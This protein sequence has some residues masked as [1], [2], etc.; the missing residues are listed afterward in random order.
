M[1]TAF[2][3]EL[4]K[5]AEEE[6]RIWL[7]C[8]DLGY[9]VLER[10]RDRFPNRYVNVGVAEQN[11]TG[12]AAG[13]ALCGKIV[14]TYS[15]ANF[16]VMRCLEQIR[17]DICYHHAN[18]KIVAVGG[19]LAYGAQGYTHHGVEDLAVM[20]VLPEMTVI[21]PGDPV[22]TRLATRAIVSYNGPCYL[23]L[24]KAG[25]PIVHQTDPK[26]EIGKAILMRD[27]SSLTLISTGGMLATVMQAAQRL[28][29]NGIAA[30][31]LS[32][33]TL[34]PLDREAILAAAAETG[35]IVTVEE[36]GIG[37]L[38]SAVAEVL[39]VAG[40]AVPFRALHLPRKPTSH[41]GT[42]ESLRSVHGLC[43]EGIVTVAR[44]LT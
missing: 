32:M 7:L 27:G 5:L 23:R 41:A 34:A 39:A 43:V 18:V 19:G 31:V 22:E 21:A 16:P 4:C 13:L 26:F 17:N 20:R 15:I 33:H 3:E 14:F 37:G 38:A 42:Q 35:G 24:G 44:A 2:I 25:E 8:G 6:E 1:R 36:H 28:A 40:Y 11:M 12:M 9:S 10:F 29:E 30:R